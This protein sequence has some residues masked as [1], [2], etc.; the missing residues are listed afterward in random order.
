MAQAMASIPLADGGFRDGESRCVCRRGGDD[1][2]RDQCDGRCGLR[3]VHWHSASG[4]TGR[5]RLG[6]H[7]AIH[8]AASALP[9]SC[10]ATPD[11]AH[12]VS[13]EG[14]RRV[15]FRR[16]ELM[17]DAII[18]WI[19]AKL[20]SVVLPSLATIAATF[21]VSL[22]KRAAAKAGLDLSR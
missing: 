2:V 18:G 4:H 21:A 6:V 14:D 16:I 9:R 10:G 8:G 17:M 19:G 13:S 12:Y 15:W 3:V 22:V 5:E 7:Q 20:L 11:P 1:C